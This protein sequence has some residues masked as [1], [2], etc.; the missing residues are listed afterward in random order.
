MVVILVNIFSVGTTVLLFLLIYAIQ[1]YL[2]SL[3]AEKA[4][5]LSV[6]CASVCS[7]NQ[8]LAIVKKSDDKIF[9]YV[10]SFLIELSYP[11]ESILFLFLQWSHCFHFCWSCL[12]FL[13]HIPKFL[14]CLCCY[15]FTSSVTLYCQFSISTISFAGRQTEMYFISPRKHFKCSFSV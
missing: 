13:Q 12:M 14:H 3:R 6:S 11:G 7:K 1:G 2:L 8:N 4:L 9:T 15:Y 10:L 5:L